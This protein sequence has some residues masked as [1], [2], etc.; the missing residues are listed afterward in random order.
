MSRN[1]KSRKAYRPRQILVNTLEVALHHAAKPARADRVE[2][3]G[4]LGKSI[5]ALC[6]GVATEQDWSIAAGAVAVAKAVE[7]QGIVRGLYEHLAHAEEAL[8]AIYDRCRLQAMWLRP[9]LTI[10]EVDALRLLQELHTFQIDN[11]GRAEFL[12]AI[13]AAHHTSIQEGHTVTLARDLERLAA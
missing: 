2:V 3:L 8:Q 13:D 4:L 7:R 11:L 12:A 9:I 10:Q 6:A 5:Q 1:K